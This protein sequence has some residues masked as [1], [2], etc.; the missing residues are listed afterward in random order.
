MP[1]VAS[2]TAQETNRHIVQALGLGAAPSLAASA[3]LTAARQA[4]NGEPSWA[5]WVPGR[6]EVLGKHTDYAGGHVLNCATDV[7]MIAVARPRRDGAVRVISANQVI[8]VPL[9]TT[10]TGSGGMSTY[11]AAVARR[12]ARHFPGINTGIDLSISANLPAAAGMSSSSALVIAVHLALAAANRL[13]ERPEYRADLATNEDLVPYLGCHENGA[14]YRRFVG[15]AGVG[16]SGGSQDH[17][18]ILCSQAGRLNHW[19]FSPFHRLA[20]VEWP[21]NVILTVAVSGVLAEKT[22]AACEH[23]NRVADR[24]RAAVALWNTASGRNDASIGAA[25]LACGGSA[26]LAKI[27]DSD[28]HQRAEQTVIETTEIVPGAVSALATGDLARFGALT[29]RSQAMAV[30]HLHNQVPE[31]I[32]LVAIAKDHGAVAASAFGAGFGGA[33]WAAFQRDDHHAEAW[34]ADYRQRFPQHPSAA[35]YHITPGPGATALELDL[36]R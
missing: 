19:S 17:A 29:A 34:I 14:G 21:Q 30:S 22:A 28:L 23:F 20:T 24:V 6:I 25:M 35:L 11:I 36:G 27:H 31:T 26:V 7:G 32:A 10:A 9:A 15:E 5:W 1:W 13:N 16:T 12:L 2:M 33:V 8:E 4:L 3:L 18:A